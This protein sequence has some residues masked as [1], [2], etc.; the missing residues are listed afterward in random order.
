LVLAT[1]GSIFWATA[2]NNINFTSI[3]TKDG[4]S[5]N[6]V[7]GILKD[8]FGLMWF[9]TE[10]GLNK[11]DGTNM[12]VYRHKADDTT[13]LRSNEILS[14][15]ED[16]SG[17]LWVG[18][19]GGGLSLYDRWKD[20][21]INFGPG[22][23]G[24]QISNNVIRGI[25]SDYQGKIWLVHFSGVNV[26]DPGTRRASTIPALPGTGNFF[27]NKS[28]LS[29]FED[30][31]HLM[32][33]GTNNGLLQYNPVTKSLRLFQHA[34][35]DPSSLSGNGV[36][37]ITEDRHGDVWI[38]TNGG[39]SRLK[40]GSNTFINYIKNSK[41]AIG[42]SSNNVNTIAVDG[43]KL[44][45]GTDE[46]LNIMDI[47][48]GAIDKFLFDNR[49]INGLTATDVRYIYV[50][51]QG[52][53]WL[54][55]VGGGVNKYDKNL[56]LFNLVK[57][58]VYDEKGLAA[59]VVSAFAEGKKGHVF[60][61]TEGGGLNI[62]NTGTRLF[63]HI[64]ISSGRK[65]FNNRIAV[66][67]LEYNQKNELLI[68]TFADG[69]FVMDPV[70]LHCR[71]LMRGG[72][73]EDINSN[74]IFCIKRDRRGNVWVGTNGGGINVLDND[75]KVIVRY[76]PNPVAPNDVNLPINGYIRDIEE[77]SDGNIWIATHGGGVA[78][79]ETASGQFNI[80]NT[81]N[82]KLPNDKVQTLLED[83]HGNIW[84]GTFGNGLAIINRHTSEVS[85]LS[86]KDGLMNNTIYKIIEDK[87]GLIWVSTNKG[88]SSIDATTKKINNYNYHNGVQNSHFVHEAG[89]LLSNG[90]I[91]FGG[92]EGFNYFN[93]KNLRKNN[94]IPKVL[95]TDLKISNRSVAPSANGPIREN[96]TVAKKIYL[97]HKQNFALSFVGLNF[98]APEQNEYAYKLEGFD[99]DWN[100]V[101]NTRAVSYTNLDPGEYVFR[102]KA[103][104]NDGIWNN[105]GTFIQISVRPPFWR[106]TYAYIIYVLALIG[107]LLYIRY[108]GIRKIKKKFATEQLKLKTEQE[109]REAERVHELDQLKI[110][111]LTN[112]SHEFR[113][114]ISLIL[115]PADKLLSRKKDEQSY[116]ELRMIT[117][118]AKRLL[119]LV[120]QLLDFQ[121]MEEHELTLQA[122]EG[123]LVSFIR[124]VCDSFRDF[125]ER[126]KI[127]FYFTSHFDE[128]HTLFDHD[129]IERILFNVI[130][131]AFKFTLE[132]G[133]IMVKLEKTDN[134][135]DASNTWV[136]ISVSDTGIGI[137][138]DKKEKIFERFFQNST[139]ASI[140][141][142][143][144]GIGLSITKEFV[145]LHG[146]TIDVESEPE[147]GATFSIRLPFV[148]LKKPADGG[149]EPIEEQ[150]ALNALLLNEPGE[151]PPASHALTGNSKTDIPAVLLVED[152]DD[153]RVYL[154]DH[155]CQYYKVVEAVNGREG[156]QRAL[157]HHPQL[158]VSDISMPQMDGIEL[159][160][161]IKSDKRTNHIPVVLLTAL[162]GEKNQLTGLGTGA[163][164]YITKPF[165]FEILNAKIKNLLA[166]ND[167]SKTTYT[168]QIKV[169]TP[170]MKIELEDEKL[171]NRIMLYLEE[172]LTDPQLS[173][174]ELSK[175]V[176]M[177]RSTLYNKILE[178]TGQTP[179]EYIRSVKLDKA[180]VLLEKSDMNVA[181]ISYSVGFATPKYFAKSFKAR[182]NMLPSEYII[183]MRQHAQ[184]KDEAG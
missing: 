97:N 181:Q 62:F 17:N 161:K 120:N 173:V 175:H 26:F 28:G 69:L 64:N 177:S 130:S 52:I 102:V 79:F 21:F 174:E 75:N 72:Q 60:V 132:G 63:Q 171:L 101:G 144:T 115:G 66:L 166:L 71:Q 35:Q 90:D 96:I 94:N 15:H 149:T 30:S 9:G 139:S 85:T 7:T 128:F 11:F 137:S 124:D 34:S 125:S 100:Y 143:G 45:L 127:G 121:K 147:K 24:S 106:T 119:N 8:R 87:Q 107:I 43:E 157:S 51:N 18:T 67:A 82:G 151:E 20:A 47:N 22:N 58:N 105:E 76:T 133:R 122:T 165:N 108:R 140:L 153:F 55:M 74:D 80:F 178:L 86:E 29:I 70:S 182:F 184:G 16:K 172:N 183:K 167:I 83:R 154:K 84:A 156:W 61:G 169:L 53:Y 91:F 158:I 103:S 160:K 131:N 40:P 36:N 39:V 46:G 168:K 4:L 89:I 2:Q 27:H 112:L 93:P 136:S 1:L 49:H 59:P 109:R 111:F 25:C 114:P 138:A 104:N 73:L 38:G 129:K 176:S 98:T 113:T 31:R 142:Q 164:D 162:T 57:S 14:L 126:K 146:G 92:L 37:V 12:T 65:G 118:N 155:L 123:E 32:W 95:I 50:D 179:V 88:I 81:T 135:A 117:R 110:K 5:S 141:N 68:G 6:T 33:I 99:K 163:N 150:P 170:E 78:A 152:D 23:R 116:S 145:R 3:T 180:A 56:N 42:L 148:E 44:W 13:S 54:G 41:D 19:S 10:D 159:T 134:A 48:T 77:D